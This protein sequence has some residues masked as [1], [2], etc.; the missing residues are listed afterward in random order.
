M[1]Y[2]DPSSHHE[3]LAGVEAAGLEVVQPLAVGLRTKPD[4][5]RPAQRRPARQHPVTVEW[6]HHHV[7]RPVHG[8]IV[9]QRTLGTQALHEGG[10]QIGAHA[11]GR[12][13]EGQHAVALGRVPVD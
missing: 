11:V 7:A 12:G 3:E 8:P 1:G 10:D 5:V 4:K 6:R 13:A 2:F 9:G